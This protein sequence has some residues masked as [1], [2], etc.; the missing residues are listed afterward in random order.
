MESMNDKEGR[1]EFLNESS[2]YGHGNARLAKECLGGA[3]ACFVEAK[4]HGHCST[5]HTT[6]YEGVTRWKFLREMDFVV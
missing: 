6:L 4:Y 5:Y 1:S 2:S 3:R